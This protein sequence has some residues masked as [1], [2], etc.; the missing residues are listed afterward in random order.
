MTEIPAALLS[1]LRGA[2][3]NDALDYAERPAQITGGF[4]TTIYAFQLTRASGEWARPLIV[5]LFRPDTEPE[6]PRFERAVHNAVASLGYPAPRVLL[7]CEDLQPL[8]GAFLVMERRPGRVMLDLF[9]RPNRKWFSL[10]RITAETHAKLHSLDAAAFE[11]AVT[12]DGVFADQ[13]H[14]SRYLNWQ[15][16]NMTRLG[17]PGLADGARWLDEHVPANP[18]NAILHGDYHPLNILMDRGAVSGVI[19]WPWA[20][21]GDPA[22]DVGATIAIFSHGP[23]D[24]PDFVRPAIDWF[25]GR[26]IA[27][28]LGEYQ[29]LR[30]IDVEAVRYY[31]ALRC[32]G[33]MME[34]GEH[35][36]ADARRIERGTKP[37]A[38]G[39][40]RQLAGIAR[41]F[42]AITGVNV[43]VQS[44]AATG[45]TP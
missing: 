45:D 28:Y 40:M 21:I 22:F 5:R 36:L 24:L 6:R 18:G 16:D 8:G 4:D 1:H 39:D 32:L 15:R 37:S 7:A 23:I 2:L 10:G 34:G 3:G 13:I 20:A 26:F 17:I 19:D 44:L 11:R 42:E 25:R 31:E 33:F 35:F 41:R 12:A 43:D 38:F 30:P 14:V 27:D 29:K 9:F